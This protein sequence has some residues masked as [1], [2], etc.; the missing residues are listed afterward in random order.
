MTP[1]APQDEEL[2]TR[3]V[4][5]YSDALTAGQDPDPDSDPNVPDPLRPRLRRL[6]DCLRRVH[7]ARPGEEVPAGASTGPEQ[8]AQPA[9][10]ADGAAPPASGLGVYGAAAGKRV[11]RFEMLRVLG[12]GGFGVVFLALD[13]VLARQV[14]LKVPRLEALL[15]PELR[16]RFLREARAAAQLDHPGLVP[17]HEAGEADGVCYIVSAYCP[18]PTLADWLRQQAEPVPPDTAARLVLRL[19]EAVQYVHDQGIWHRD[20]KPRNVLLDP[21]PPAEGGLPFTPRLTDFGLALAADRVEVTQSGAAGTPAYMAPEQTGGRVR[22]IGP[23]TDVYGLGALLYEVL[24][25][26]PP[27]GGPTPEATL[28]QVEG[29]DPPTPTRLRP[30]L[31]RDLE[32]VCLKC[33]EKAPRRRYAS[34]RELADRLRR[35]LDGRPIPDPPR[36]WPARLARAARRRPLL[37]AAAVLLGLALAGGLA[38]GYYFDPQRPRREVTWALR[39]GRAYEFAGHERLPGPFRQ[40]VGNV[41]GLT[42]DA[43]EKCVTLETLDVSLWELT[44]DPQCEHYRFSA[45]VRHDRTAAGSYVGLYFGRR[46][47]R[48]ADGD[49]QAGFY[50]L[51]FADR[52]AYARQKEG[53]EP[54]G[55]VEVQANL[56]GLDAGR[57]YTPQAG[58]A[59][60][61]AFRPAV[62]GLPTA[63]PAPW[64]QLAV[65]VTP[66]GAWARWAGDPGAPPTAV[67]V[68]A[69]SLELVLRRLEKECPELAGVPAEHRTRSG[70]GLYVSGG[71]ASFRNIVVQPLDRGD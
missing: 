50:T 23:H 41:P 14:A 1:D 12:S 53:G 15:S 59:R 7:A 68:S 64:R 38:A 49:P 60:V 6:L 45:E 61:A 13:P 5:A 19:A 63:E 34:A 56:C 58:L 16:Q 3:L 18:G 52:G 22:E 65:E 24:T 55:W 69:A 20:I 21:A 48:T 35:F 67:A 8:E 31:P 9:T 27:F 32:T 36:R 51:V 2:F 70:L 47:H 54:R 62:P 71:A 28:R 46:E 57:P 43:G 40:V 66:A 17:V 44:D 25:G 42:R 30:G 4:A 26:R 10:A 39:R 37:S 11:G 33:L 29:E